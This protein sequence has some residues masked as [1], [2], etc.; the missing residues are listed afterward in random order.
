MGAAGFGVGIKHLF[1][2]IKLDSRSESESEAEHVWKDFS[3][4]SNN[5][6]FKVKLRETSKLLPQLQKACSGK[7]H[8]KIC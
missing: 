3:C 8:L 1:S 7:V 4:D 5:L 2:S 6:I